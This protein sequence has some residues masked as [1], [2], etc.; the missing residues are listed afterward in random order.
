[1]AL[2]NCEQCGHGHVCH[3]TPS[4]ADRGPVSSTVAAAVRE[5]E[6]GNMNAYTAMRAIQ[7]AARP[8]APAP[9]RRPPVS[10]SNVGQG[11]AGAGVAVATGIEIP[12]RWLLGE[13]VASGLRDYYTGLLSQATIEWSEAD[14]FAEIET[15]VSDPNPVL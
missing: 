7:R 6:N 2:T 14:P 13:N 8:E 3:L 4:E 11:E 12:Q 10:M 1:M 9:R 15:I 5:W